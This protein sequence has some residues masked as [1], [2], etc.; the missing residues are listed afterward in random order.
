MAEEGATLYYVSKQYFDFQKAYNYLEKVGL[1]IR[2]LN[3]KLITGINKDGEFV[4]T[5]QKNIQEMIYGDKNSGIY[6]YLESGH[7]ILWSFVEQKDYFFQNFSF[8]YLNYSQT[9]EIVSKVF[10]RFAVEELAEVDKEFLGFTL[11][12]YGL[13][14]DYNFGEIFEYGSKEMLSSF[15]ISDMTFLPTNKINRIA[16]DNECKIIQLNQNFNCISKNE[17]LAD[18][19]KTFIK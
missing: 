13:T 17:D 3:T 19:L 12:R 2:H 8:N 9:E 1:H 6:L 11:D 16:M 10:V 5:K 4:E 18:Y 15:Y 7:R 14:E